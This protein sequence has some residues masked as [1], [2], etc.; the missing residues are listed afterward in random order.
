MPYFDDD[1]PVFKRNRWGTNRYE[2]NPRNPVGC[3]LIVLV[4]VFAAVML[5]LMHQHA[6]P[7]AHP[8]DT[9]PTPSA[10]ETD[11]IGRYAPPP[12]R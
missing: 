12:T 3:A 11:D 7:F 2:F 8:S 4:L 6:G 1:E 10:T 9:A 5:L